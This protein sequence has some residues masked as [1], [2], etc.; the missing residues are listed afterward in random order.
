MFNAIIIFNNGLHNINSKQS[1]EKTRF[2]KE[3]S[4]T[5]TFDL[6]KMRLTG[7]K[8]FILDFRV[9]FFL[10]STLFLV[11]KFHGKRKIFGI[12][13]LFMGNKICFATFTKFNKIY[14]IW[15]LD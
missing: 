11:R 7:I 2:V 1:I 10:S 5:I 9:I 15:P 12:R 14:K 3:E 4:G 8:T 13:G 6:L